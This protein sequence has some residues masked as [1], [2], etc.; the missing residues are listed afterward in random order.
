ML[1]FFAFLLLALLLA[2]PSSADCVPTRSDVV[3]LERQGFAVPG[4]AAAL[5]ATYYVGNDACQLDAE[6]GCLFSVWV[7]KESNGVEGWQRGDEGHED[8]HCGAGPDD[9]DV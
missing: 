2:S 6:E 7:G 4:S 1:R 5:G 9:F 8:T 3:T